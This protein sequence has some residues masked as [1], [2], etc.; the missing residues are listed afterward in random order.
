MPVFPQVFQVIPPSILAM[1]PE[2]VRAATALPERCSESVPGCMASLDTF[3]QEEPSALRNKPLD[4][5]ASRTPFGKGRS[6]DT[7]VLP[8]GMRRE[9]QCS[10]P[11]FD[12]EIP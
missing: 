5:A 1:A 10:P 6:A 9:V 12:S 3:V 8:S 2:F 11:S 7:A 4:V